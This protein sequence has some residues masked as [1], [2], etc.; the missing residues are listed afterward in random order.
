L[1]GVMGGVCGLRDDVANLEVKHNVEYDGDTEKSEGDKGENIDFAAHRFEVAEQFL[2]FKGVAVGGFADGLEVV[3]D[4]LEG[5]ILL[6]NLIAKSALLDAE[7]GK[8]FLEGHD[9]SW[10]LRRGFW[11]LR[12]EHVGECGI[13]LSIEERQHALHEGQCHAK[14]A[15][16]AFN[17]GAGLSGRRRQLARR[18]GD[19]RRRRIWTRIERGSLEILLHKFPRRH[20]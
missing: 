11:L 19:R 6:H 14:D 1:D 13:Y 10:R 3:F 15:R 16:S 2:L 17:S 4:A 5:G 20:S 18:G 12:G 8:A 9:V 7:I